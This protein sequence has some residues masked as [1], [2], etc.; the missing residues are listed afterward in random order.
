MLAAHEIFGFMSPGLAVEIVQQL[1]DTNREAY[2]ATLAAVAESRRL[3]PVFLE[4]KPRAEQHK[5]VCESLAKPRLEATA[6]TTLQ[7]WLLKHESAMLCDYLNALEI[8]HENGAVDDLPKEMDD[9]KLE[10]AVEG[11]LAK[12]PQE[13][14]GV[15]LRAFNDLSQAKW[16]NLARKLDED[17]R[18]QLGG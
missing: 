15:Y 6:I 7:N 5:A 18:L 9:A 17:P 10:A 13:K 16:P 3:R 14:V 11:L 4:R 12:Y 2:R 8:K 1:H